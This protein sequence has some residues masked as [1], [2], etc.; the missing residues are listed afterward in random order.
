MQGAGVAGFK[1]FVFFTIVFLLQ[2][3]IQLGFSREICLDNSIIL[4]VDDP[5]NGSERFWGHL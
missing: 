1:C 2:P 5:E 4:N 3:D